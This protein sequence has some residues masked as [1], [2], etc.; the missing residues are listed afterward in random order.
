MANPESNVPAQP[1]PQAPA[2]REEG[3][4]P[5][6]TLRRE[7]DRLFDDFRAP[8]WPFAAR[9]AGAAREAGWPSLGALRLAPAVDL[10]EKDG[11]WELTAELPGLDEKNVEV[12]VAGGTLTIRGEKQE[13]KE[14]KEKEYHLS[15][16]R[17]GAFRRSFRLPE[18]VDAEK[19]E[20]SFANGVLTVTLP[21]SA[22]AQQGA[23]TIPVKPG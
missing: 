6:D 13:T 9:R 12:T 23:K 15:E 2:P 4:S 20:A 3:W 5:F 19:I 7:V 10:V 22:E 18:G 8:G 14:E 1:A 11:A 16:R 21:K 17:F